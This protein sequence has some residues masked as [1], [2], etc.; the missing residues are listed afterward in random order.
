MSMRPQDRGPE[1]T[2]VGCDEVVG[3]VAVP[4]VAVVTVWTTV[5]VLTTV[6]VFVFPPPQPAARTT[7][8]NASARRSGRRTARRLVQLGRLPRDLHEAL[9]ALRRAEAKALVEPVRVGGDEEHPPQPLQVRMG[10]HRLHQPDAEPTAA[11]V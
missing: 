5:S 7:T 11:V 10:E 4:V 9:D 2:G 1:G 8:T 6:S 3:V